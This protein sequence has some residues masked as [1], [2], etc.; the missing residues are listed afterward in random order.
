M[1][2][3]PMKK[4]VYRKNFEER[5]DW[6]QKAQKDSFRLKYHIQPPMGWLNDPN[7]LCQKDGVYHIYFQYCPFYPELGSIFWG[8]MTTKDFLHYE[9]HEP[10]LY[11]DTKWDCNGPYS[12]SAY[13]E[14]GMIY[15]F[16]TGNVRYEGDYNYVTDGREQNTILVTSEDGFAFSGKQLLMKNEDYPADMSRHVRDPQVFRENG[17]YFMIQGARSIQDEG[18]ILL[19]ESEDLIHWSYKLRFQPGKPFGYMWECP[20]YLKIGERKFLFTCP[21]GVPRDDYEFANVYQCGWFSLDYDFKGEDYR[22]GEF[23]SLDRGFDFYAPQ[24]FQDEAGRWILLGWMAIPDS[25]YEEPTLAGGWIHALTIPRELYVNEA[26]LL[27]QRPLKELEGMRKTAVKGTLREG[28]NR[29][30]SPCFELKLLMDKAAGEFELKLR[31]SAAL[32]YRDGVLRLDVTGCGSGRTVRRL[33][34]EELWK[35]QIFSDTSSLE[36][37]VNDGADVFTTRVYDSMEDLRIS[38]EAVELLGD[39]EYYSFESEFNN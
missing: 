28:L 37:F 25:G 13:Q 4:D 31:E 11:S 36:I 1:V 19:F 8:H 22:L 5:K 26:G 6:Y 23:H 16:Y 29:E 7:G 21:Q 3:S 12:G 9:E 34:V 30:T 24:V 38:L 18:S 39:W 20:N 27:C 10:A 17:R 35:L 32:A 15:F 14:N 33:K 2:K